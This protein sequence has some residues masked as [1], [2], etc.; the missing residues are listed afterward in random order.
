MSGRIVAKCR[1][2]DAGRCRFQFGKSLG[3][4]A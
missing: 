1:A 4:R 3:L 2:A